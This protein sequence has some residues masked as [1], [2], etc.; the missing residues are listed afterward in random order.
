MSNSEQ[1]RTALK[2]L[3]LA[4]RAATDLHDSPKVAA[5]CAQVSQAYSALATYALLRDRV[6]IRTEEAVLDVSAPHPTP[7]SGW[8]NTD[9]LIR[10]LE[11]WNFQCQGPL[12]DDRQRDL[13]LFLA[14]QGVT[15]P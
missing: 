6:A 12:S 15:A 7:P 13:A 2:A 11:A 5:A 8:V 14:A 4:Q 9:K 3:Q 1:S 10:M